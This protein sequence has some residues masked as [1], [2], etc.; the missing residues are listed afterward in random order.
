MPG[1]D[2]LRWSA[3]GSPKR[4]EVSTPR[5][6]T[7]SETTAEAT[8]S[9]PRPPP[10]GSLAPPPPVDLQLHSSTQP[11]LWELT[12]AALLFVNKHFEASAPCPHFEQIKQHGAYSRTSNSI[13]TS[14]STSSIM[15]CIRSM[16]IS[17]SNSMN[18]SSM[19]TSSGT[20]GSMSMSSSRRM[21]SSKSLSSCRST[22]NN[23][24]TSSS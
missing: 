8:P 21:G 12:P 9:L 23:R 7:L 24:S 1:P 22:H 10:S 11:Y 18:T 2:W 6:S 20:S 5:S 4:A 15:S 13:S 17:R 19:S 14:S 3:P 16:S